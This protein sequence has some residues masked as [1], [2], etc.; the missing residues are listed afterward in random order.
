MPAKS[1]SLEG[2]GTVMINPIK[3]KEKDY[4]MVSQ[5]G[6]PV[7]TK[8]VGERA[9]SIYVTPDGTE[10]PRSMVCKKILIEDEELIL[11]KFQP[12]KAVSKDNIVETDDASLVYR[13]MSRKFYNVV[14]DNPE[15]KRLVLEENKSLEFPLAVGQGWKIWKG[16]LTNW[17]GRLILVA[18]IGDLQKELAKYAEDTVELELDIMPQVKDMKKLVTAMAMV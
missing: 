14:T 1:L 13:A 11:P 2:Y 4:E 5:D 10:V 15:I 16:I 12:T 6:T 3:V 8:M 7:S 9:K 17:N 18:C